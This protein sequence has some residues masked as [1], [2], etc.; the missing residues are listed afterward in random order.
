MTEIVIFNGGEPLPSTLATEIAE[1]AY[2][3][4]ADSGLDTALSWGLDVDLVV[5]DLDSVGADSVGATTA[6][7]QSHSPDKDATDLELAL[8]AAM[9]RQPDRI[10]VLGGQGGRLDHLLA[11]AQLLVS[12]RWAPVEL[13]WVAT[14]A[15]VLVVRHGVSIHGVEGGLLTLLAV[16]R[17]AA[18]VTTTGLRWNLDDATLLPGS[19]HGVSNR[20][21]NPVAT[22]RLTTG[23]LLAIQP[24]RS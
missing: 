4:A 24:D 15:R 18:G 2:T 22:L 12:D 21:V 9:R 23:T 3:I 8:I 13:E 10:L 14:R 16:G 5:G 6:E 19:T 7:V 11:T 17:K 20:F 1:G